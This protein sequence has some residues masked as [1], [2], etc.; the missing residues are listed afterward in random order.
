MKTYQ[1]EITRDGKWWMIHIPEVDGLTQARRLSEANQMAREYI[2]LTTNTSI[3]NIKVETVIKEIANLNIAEEMTIITQ[4]R[5]Q[6]KKLESDSME[7]AT[8]LAKQLAAK[9]IPVRDIGVIIGQSYQRAHQ[10]IQK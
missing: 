9:E 10:L 3:D 4:E 8:E 2:A 7:R 6:A 5:E 1:A